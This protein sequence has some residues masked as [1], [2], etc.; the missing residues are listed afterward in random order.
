M[1]LGYE[2]MPHQSMYYHTTTTQQGTICLW[3]FLEVTYVKWDGGRQKPLKET[4][5]FSLDPPMVPTEHLGDLRL[6]KVG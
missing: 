3:M 2:V 4:Y 5:Q 6:K 1:C